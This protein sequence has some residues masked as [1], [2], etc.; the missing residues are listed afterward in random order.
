M[1]PP[2]CIRTAGAGQGWALKADLTPESTPALEP[3]SQPSLLGLGGGA[4]GDL[5]GK[6]YQ[7]EGVTCSPRPLGP[8]P[9]VG[10]TVL[11]SRLEERAGRGWERMFS[12]SVK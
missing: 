8:S 1:R 7:L 5:G 6:A 10:M 3:P 9:L 2:A 12:S 11:L 4:A